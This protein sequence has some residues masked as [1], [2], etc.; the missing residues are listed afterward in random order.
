MILVV[1]SRRR[2][3][4][5]RVSDEPPPPGS[6]G[7]PRGMYIPN[8]VA[9]AAAILGARGGL[10]RLACCVLLAVTAAGDAA[11]Q[12]LQLPVPAGDEV[13][14]HARP[15][16]EAPLRTVDALVREAL[17][18]APSLAAARARLA[19]AREMVAPAGALPDPMAELMLTDVGFPRWSVGGDAM[20]MLG[21]EF[22]QALPYPGKRAA[23]RAAAAAEAAARG[24]EL[25]ALRR[26]VIAQVRTMYARVYA[27]D[28]ERET[29]AAAQELLD[30]LAATVAARYAVG[31][32]E[33]EAV[34]KAQL[35]RSRLG[36]RLDDLDAE[37]AALVAGLNRLLDRPGHTP[38][39][40]VEALPPVSPPGDD[41]GALAAAASPAVALR[42]AEV[43]AAQG[44]LEVARLELKPDLRAAGAFGYRSG[45][46]PAVTLRFGVEWP[47]WRRQKQEPMLRAAER[48]LEMAHAEL[49]DAEAVARAEAARLRAGW[50]R[51]ERQL[52]RL[53]EAIVPQSSAAID[54][55][56]ASYLAGRGDF[57]TV[58]EDFQLWLDARTQLAR[59]EAERF[60]IWAELDRL[61][62]SAATAA[63]EGAVP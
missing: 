23:R 24:A 5:S 12:P 4:V 57:S 32:A 59:R 18:R 48:E 40:E 62:T 46:D 60:V 30:L 6:P 19:A 51:V 36:E 42:Q 38:L 11:G 1:R 21:P 41:W 27:L 22:R 15:I 44:R 52:R 17:Q 50:E 49:R 14:G 37:R 25:E 45:F 9:A 2:P 55:A 26:E 61:C 56:R 43:A 58:I 20:S 28:K 33:Q 34:V 29:L 39:G 10:R 7:L 53:R 8:V 13:P 54:A 31:E 47:L 3:G 16:G 63:G 35:A